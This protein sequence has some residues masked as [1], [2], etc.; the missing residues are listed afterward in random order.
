MYGRHDNKLKS[1][2]HSLDT[3][4][5]VNFR[6]CLSDNNNKG[7]FIIED[8]IKYPSDPNQI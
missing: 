5:L 2:R 7:L 4:F 8:V 1:F 6:C 3:H